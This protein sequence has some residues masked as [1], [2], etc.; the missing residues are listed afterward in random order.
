MAAEALHIRADTQT[1][2]LCV[3]VHGRGQSPEEMQSHIVERLDVP[4]VTFVLP[5]AESGV[6]YE[7][8]AVD[9][10]TDDGRAALEASLK[11]LAAD[12]AETRATYGEDLPLVLAG[13]SQGACLSLEY[14][15][16]GRRAPEALVAFTGCRVGVRSDDRP[17]ALA[18]GL[19]VYLTG[20]DADL[21]IPT[22]AFCEAALELGEGRAR[23]RT[24]VLPGRAH[25][26]ADA[27]IAMLQSILTDLAA[28]KP[29]TMGAG[30]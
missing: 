17:H 29:V 13:F 26:V 14:A 24:D 4:D 5:R 28:G 19:P 11:Q 2:A 9:P 18:D 16:S 8:K 3:L 6:W 21:W 7:V 1:R 25:E 22:T 15:F 12:I 30:R 23:L 20:S 27:E 10:L